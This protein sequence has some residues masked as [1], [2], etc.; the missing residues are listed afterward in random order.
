MRAPLIILLL[1]LLVGCSKPAAVVVSDAGLQARLDSY[2][3]ALLAGKQRVTI[4]MMDTRFFPSPE[5]RQESVALLEKSTTIFVY[6]TI[7][8][9]EPFGQFR[10]SNSVHCFVPYVSDAEIRGQRA[11]VK[12]YLLATRYEGSTDWFFVDIGTKTRDVLARY[13]ENLPEDLPKASL[14]KKE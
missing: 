14:E 6:H 9:G 7:T 5:A 2:F 3:G 12:S 8:N 10:G 11:T 13:Y 1:G 4:D